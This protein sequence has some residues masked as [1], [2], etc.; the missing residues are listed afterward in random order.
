M[1]NLNLG[2]G[3][4]A[5]NMA[6]G[7]HHGPLTMH[8]KYATI[9]LT[10]ITKEEPIKQLLCG[11]LPTIDPDYFV[12]RKELYSNLVKKFP[13]LSEQKSSEIPPSSILTIHG[14]GGSGKTLLAAHYVAQTSQVYP[15]RVW[16]QAES[17]E[18]LHQSYRSF[19][20]MLGQN[21]TKLSENPSDK[22]IVSAVTTWLINNP[23]WLI[24]YDNVDTYQEIKP[25]LPSQGG[26]ILLISRLEPW[27]NTKKIKVEGLLKEEAKELVKRRIWDNKDAKLSEK[28]Q[29]ALN[30]L[31]HELNY[32]PLALAQASAYIA[33]SKG[34]TTISQYLSLYQSC[35][36]KMLNENLLAG[37]YPQAVAKTWLI[38]MK[39]IEK[40]LPIALQVLEGCAYLA[41]TEIP[42]D[43]IKQLTK[44]FFL[45]E[46]KENQEILERNPTELNSVANDITN[47]LNDYSM[48][49][50]NSRQK[51]YNTHRLVEQILRLKIQPPTFKEALIQ[52]V[53]ESLTHSVPPQDEEKNSA[54]RRQPW[55]A[56]LAAAIHYYKTGSW[57]NIS[58]YISYI[59]ALY[60]LGA[61]HV[62]DWEN[63]Q[64]GKY[65]LEEAKNIIE[66]M[67][68][69]K[70][71]IYITLAKVLTVLGI[72]HG[73]L[74]DHHEERVV[75]EYALQVLNKR[76][77][78]DPDQRIKILIALA[79]AHGHLGYPI[80]KCELLKKA[81]EIHQETHDSR[82][83]HTVEIIY[84][85]LCNVYGDLGLR[86]EKNHIV[87]NI[88]ST[89][90]K[91][92]DNKHPTTA[93][94]LH[95]VGKFHFE[96]GEF[97]E[98][99][100]L[101]EESLSIKSDYFG[102]NH[103][104][105]IMTLTLLGDCW[106]KQKNYEK[107]VT[108]LEHALFI[109]KN[110][111]N[112]DPLQI[113]ITCY[114]LGQAYCVLEDIEE[115]K[116]YFKEAFPIFSKHHT[117][118]SVCTSL[119]DD[120]NEINRITDLPES[121]KEIAIQQLSQK[122]QQSNYS[123]LSTSVAI[124]SRLQIIQQESKIII[125]ALKNFALQGSDINKEYFD[126]TKFNEEVH[127]KLSIINRLL[128][129]A[130]EVVSETPIE[131]QKK[132]FVE[133]Y[134]VILLYLKERMHDLLKKKIEV[135]PYILPLSGMMDIM[136]ILSGSPRTITDMVSGINCWI[137]D[138]E[139]S[140]LLAYFPLNTSSID[141]LSSLINVIGHEGT[142]REEKGYFRVSLAWLQQL[143]KYDTS[144][145]EDFIK[146]T[147]LQEIL[148][149]LDQ[150]IEDLTISHKKAM[151]MI[152]FFGNYKAYYFENHLKGNHMDNRNQ[153]TPP[154]VDS[155]TPGP[156]QPAATPVTRPSRRAEAT[157]TGST[158][159]AG[160]HFTQDIAGAGAEGIMRDSTTGPNA[161]I[162]QKVRG[163]AAAEISKMT[164]LENAVIKQI[165]NE[166]IDDKEEN[167]Q[168]R[169]TQEKY[170]KE[171]LSKLQQEYR[172][173]EEKYMILLNAISDIEK[174]KKDVEGIKQ[175]FDIDEKSVKE[176]DEILQDE[177][178]H[179]YYQTLRKIQ[180]HFN[181]AKMIQTSKIPQADDI[182]DIAI[183]AA[184][185]LGK[186][187]PG[188]GVIPQLLEQ[189]ALATNGILKHQAMK[190]LA[191]WI[192]DSKTTDR[193][194][195]R[196]ARKMTLAKKATIYQVT[197][198]TEDSKL[199]ETHHTA[200]IASTISE[201]IHRGVESA[202]LMVREIKEGV[203]YSPEERLA[204]TD[205]TRVLNAIMKGEITPSSH[206]SNEKQL[207]DC[208]QK[209]LTLFNPLRQNEQ[210]VKSVPPAATFPSSS[211]PAQTDA[212]LSLLTRPPQSTDDIRAPGRE[213]LFG[214][215]QQPTA[216][217]NRPSEEAGNDATTP[218]LS[219]KP[220]SKFKC[221]SIV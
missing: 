51:T 189:G 46:K 127:E 104:Q 131:N 211:Q 72:A 118:S 90:I 117:L 141:Y 76:T 66:N 162:K 26:N 203:S 134:T 41:D 157:L 182:A 115:S 14:L 110:Q 8:T 63:G 125:T 99:S 204:L 45:A 123:S 112:Y 183:K 135:T 11:N 32:L 160:T 167:K 89:M 139:N 200:G 58:S 201:T 5:T 43:I 155:K 7:H 34:K 9:S 122:H 179:A 158:I 73:L 178:L 83:D 133:T 47:L 197:S 108:Y 111:P 136:S 27:G 175:E 163:D 164:I 126:P 217:A 138:T 144:K 166:N 216:T 80:I 143:D 50:W 20:N 196:F 147:Q 195:E 209:M 129:V 193:L 65:Y 44:T 121:E 202:T 79:N 21:R 140:K 177:K 181:V 87:K 159:G 36:E 49:G 24:V 92:Y 69:G 70:S 212:G 48:M 161:K 60:M 57:E 6:I 94:L 169:E 146:G 199:K 52:N 208:L 39:A 33:R 124:D 215:N 29:T 38:T 113:A 180:Y 205:T 207:D 67:F 105:L 4:T 187:F 106:L 19:C 22:D 84:V 191:D 149:P 30:K 68:V 184:S 116:R 3:A 62:D 77:R 220:S 40:Q 93:I 153:P 170:L 114:M 221:C 1:Q 88:F 42:E 18:T 210:E 16:F 168:E 13:A 150:D 71:Y 137:S 188:V 59:I 95:N 101:L 132:R 82:F 194:S 145:V 192:T 152:T 12:E 214:G 10:T 174:L 78:D 53:L 213:G 86:K 37:D 218:L 198:T 96:E 75:L 23:Y 17:K 120:I 61:I 109:Q 102:S 97:Q 130:H 64:Q 31:I 56:H 91:R 171:A 107:A 206:L 35:T 148:F 25:Y 172:L 81:L 151:P 98:A 142:L 156:S 103:S 154:A 100:S 54:H 173:S 119:S 74:N 55:I 176:R 2:P 28:S 190:R 15:V 128:E 85:N 186:H 219:S 185:S 165:V